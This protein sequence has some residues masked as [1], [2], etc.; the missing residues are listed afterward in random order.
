MTQPPKNL[1]KTDAER[2]LA[3][4]LVIFVIALGLAIVLGLAGVFVNQL[5][6]A[7]SANYST[8]AIYAAD[9]GLE[10]ALYLERRQGGLTSM[11]TWP[12]PEGGAPC[13][14]VTLPAPSPIFRY[15]AQDSGG[16]RTVKALGSYKGTNRALE[17]WYPA[18]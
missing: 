3:V 9:A 13:E 16:T 14:Q 11:A 7:R 17:I 12:C 8:A 5:F 18:P 2:G 4:L 15:Y 6:I 10:R 1:P